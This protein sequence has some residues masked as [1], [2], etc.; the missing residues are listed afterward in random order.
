GLTPVKAKHV[1]P[2][3][4]KECFAHLECKVVNEIPTGDHT[5][6]VGEVVQ[7]TVNKGI[8]DKSFDTQKIRPV[9]HNGYDDF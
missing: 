2:P 1:K 7:A 8:F 5:I 6:F 3:L 4:I 9:L